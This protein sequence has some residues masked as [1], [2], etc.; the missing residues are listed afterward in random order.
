MLDKFDGKIIVNL[1]VC[2]KYG[3]NLLVVSIED[4]KFI[5]NFK[6]NIVLIKGKKIIVFGFNKDINCLLN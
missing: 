2:N 4:E 6:F 5:I 3:L 1:E